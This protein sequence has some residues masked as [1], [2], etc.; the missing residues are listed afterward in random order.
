MGGRAVPAKETAGTAERD[1]E[2]HAEADKG[3]AIARVRF[4]TPSVEV[5]IDAVPARVTLALTSRD[6]DKLIEAD[7]VPVTS[8]ST[9][10]TPSVVV[11]MS[12]VY[13]VR[14]PWMERA[15]TRLATVELGAHRGFLVAAGTVVCHCRQDERQLSMERGAPEGVLSRLTARAPAMGTRTILPL[16]P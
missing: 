11:E 12:V 4:A 16:A 13:F 2:R 10:A 8:R 3:P 15:Y 6:P 7:R 14:L 5:A 1:P 9:L